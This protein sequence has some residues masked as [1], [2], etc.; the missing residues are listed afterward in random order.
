MCGPDL[1]PV[2]STYVLLPA[3][4]RKIPGHGSGFALRL[5]HS[6][7]KVIHSRLW[8]TTGL[9][10]A[11]NRRNSRVRVDAPRT[12][13]EAAGRI[14]RLPVRRLLAWAVAIHAERNLFER[15][16]PAVSKRTFQPNNRRRA[17]N[18]GFRLRMRTRAGRAIIA[19]RR[20][21]GRAR[22]SA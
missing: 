16:E 4:M 10:T 3:V 8:I 11:M 14:I 9:S 5:L 21:R 19:T 22:L 2:P 12:P 1:C 7:S 20:R 15:G 13:N 18:H 17:K 6:T